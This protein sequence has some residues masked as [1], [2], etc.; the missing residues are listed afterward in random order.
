MYNSRAVKKG[1]LAQLVEHALD[2]RRVSGSS[3]LTS[4]KFIYRRSSNYQELLLC[5]SNLSHLLPFS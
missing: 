4:T 5:L 1:H 2:V 3:P